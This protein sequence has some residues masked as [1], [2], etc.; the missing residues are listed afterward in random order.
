MGWLSLRMMVPFDKVIGTKHHNWHPARMAVT[1]F[2][3]TH[4]QGVSR[5][6][7]CARHSPSFAAANRSRMK[8]SKG[9]NYEA[10]AKP[11]FWRTKLDTTTLSC[12]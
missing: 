6:S 2:T 3:C 5:T 1:A 8:A 7:L 12:E 11:S 4:R 9:A 10:I